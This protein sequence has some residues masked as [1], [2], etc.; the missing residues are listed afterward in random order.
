MSSH[1]KLCSYCSGQGHNIRTCPNKQMDDKRNNQYE[2]YD[3]NFSKKEILLLKDLKQA[4]SLD[5]KP[6]LT[7]FW[8]QSKRPGGY[9][10]LGKLKVC[11]DDGLKDD[12]IKL[13]ITCIDAIDEI[14]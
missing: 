8:I 4:Q 9:N 7:L 3:V 6:E 5:L 12:Y 1:T 13:F 11:I 2:N 14:Y 10:T